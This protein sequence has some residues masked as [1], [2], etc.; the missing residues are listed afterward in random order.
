MADKAPLLRAD[1]VA[2][3]VAMAVPV[4][5]MATPVDPNMCYGSYGQV[6]P[7][8]SESHTHEPHHP[9]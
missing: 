2:V 8:V 9:T 5:A 1:A 3:P 6:A 4:N 7:V